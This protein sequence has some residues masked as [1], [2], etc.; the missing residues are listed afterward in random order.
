[1]LQVPSVTMK[2]GS[3]TSATSTPLMKPQAMPVRKPSTKAISGGQPQ[4]TARRPMTIDDSTMMAPTERSMPAVRITSV[5]AMPKVPMMVTCCR[6]SDMLNRAKNLP[7][8]VTEKIMTPTISTMNGIAVG[9]S[10][11]K[12]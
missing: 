1:M 4:T 6:T 7:P 10:C 11:R 2:G 5:W 8:A 12:R 9:N 3:L